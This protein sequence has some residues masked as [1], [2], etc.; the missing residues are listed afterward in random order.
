LD[1]LINNAGVF[2]SPISQTED[3]PLYSISK[4]AKN[5][6]AKPSLFNIKSS[7]TLVSRK[8]FI[9]MPLSEIKDASS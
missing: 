7:M 8:T 9:T 1:V 6:L 4:L 3:V 2:E 5:S